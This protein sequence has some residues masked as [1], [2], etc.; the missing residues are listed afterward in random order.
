MSILIVRSLLW[1]YSIGYF[2]PQKRQII[3]DLVFSG[4]ALGSAGGRFAPHLVW[5]GAWLQKTEAALCI[6]D[7]GRFGAY[8]FIKDNLAYQPGGDAGSQASR[9]GFAC[10]SKGGMNVKLWL[11]AFADGYYANAGHFVGSVNRQQHR[12]WRSFTG[13]PRTNHYLAVTNA[14]YQDD[15]PQ[16]YAVLLGETLNAMGQHI[17]ILQPYDEDSTKLPFTGLH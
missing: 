14:T 13:A 17:A 4:S 6:L 3:L 15:V 1:D 9:C 5:L 10:A 2:G 12:L 16:R 11:S 8:D 7:A